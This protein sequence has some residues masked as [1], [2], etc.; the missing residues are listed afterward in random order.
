MPHWHPYSVKNPSLF[1]FVLTPHWTITQLFSFLTRHCHSLSFLTR[2]ALSFLP[3][4][5]WRL[6]NLLLLLHIT[7]TRNGVASIQSLALRTMSP[8]CEAPVQCNVVTISSV[9]RKHVQADN[10]VPDLLTVWQPARP[11][12]TETRQPS[13]ATQDQLVHYGSA[14]GF[15]KRYRALHLL[16]FFT[17]TLWKVGG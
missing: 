16:N 6:H 12:V 14:S 10:S 1:F 17:A 9:C 15:P 13:Q 5:Q 2:H 8:R 4:Q 7:K 11:Q 3:P